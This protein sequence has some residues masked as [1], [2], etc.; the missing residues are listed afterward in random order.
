MTLKRLL[1]FRKIFKILQTPVG[2]TRRASC[3]IFFSTLLNWDSFWAKSTIWLW[4]SSSPPPPLKNRGC[5]LATTNHYSNGFQ[6]VGHRAFWFEKVVFARWAV[7][8]LTLSESLQK[9][10]WTASWQFFGF[11]LEITLFRSKKTFKF[12]W[13]PFFMEITWF[14]PEKPF[15][16]NSRL[17]KIWVKLLRNTLRLGPWKIF[18]MKMGHG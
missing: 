8:S 9:V 1:F 16:S 13:R 7:Y 4:R 18:K 11:V 12:W 2:D 6:P 15:Q 5:V 14:R 10:A 17:M 3:T